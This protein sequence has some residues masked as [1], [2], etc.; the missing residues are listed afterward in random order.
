MNQQDF[1]LECGRSYLD[2][3]AAMGYFRAVVQERCGRVVGKHKAVL[4]GVLGV[5]VDD[6]KWSPY[7]KP[8]KPS[9]AAVESAWL[10]WQAKRKE[11]LYLH[12]YVGWDSEPDED[13]LPLNVEVDLWLKDRKKASDL[14]ARL[15]DRC[16]QPPFAEQPWKFG[17]DGQTLSFWLGLEENEFSRF[18]EKLDQLLVF[19]IPFLRSVKNIQGYFLP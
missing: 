15:D 14:A 16:D 12:F 8:D 17:S 7:A 4:A 13:E 3:L 1:L 10:G 18:G 6:L 9:S 19:I 2:V 5:K 11:D